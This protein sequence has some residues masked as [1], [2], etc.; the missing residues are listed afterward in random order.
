MKKSVVAL[1]LLGM[2]YSRADRLAP[3]Y[4]RTDPITPIH[5]GISKYR[6]RSAL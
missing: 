2:A 5:H 1:A 6:Q 4:S 3:K